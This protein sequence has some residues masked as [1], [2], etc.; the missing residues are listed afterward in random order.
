MRTIRSAYTDS[1]VAMFLLAYIHL[2]FGGEYTIRAFQSKR[3]SPRKPWTTRICLAV[4]GLLLILTWLPSNIIRAPQKCYGD[5]IWRPFRVIP[6]GLGITSAMIVIFMGMAAI[7]G[8][9]LIRT[10]NIDP[11]E[12]IAASRV[13]Y[14][15]IASIV[16][17]ILML[18]FF[19]QGVLGDFDKDLSSARLAEL[20]LVGAGII[21]SLIHIFLRTNALRTAL[22]PVQTAWTPKR[23]FR[24]FGNSDLEIVNISPPVNLLGP[25]DADYYTNEKDRTNTRNEY[26]IPD[27]K[28]P[29]EAENLYTIPRTPAGRRESKWPLPAEPLSTPKPAELGGASSPTRSPP[30]TARHKRTPTNYSLFPNAEDEGPKLPAA[31]YSPTSPPPV[32]KKDRPESPKRIVQPDRSISAILD[33]YSSSRDTFQPSDQEPLI[34]LQPT[35][36]T[37]LEKS[38]QEV[39]SLFLQPPAPNFAINNHRRGSSASSTATL[40]IGLRLSMAPSAAIG[41]PSSVPSWTPPPPPASGPSRLKALMTP[42]AEESESSSTVTTPAASSASQDVM[43]ENPSKLL[44]QRQM[45]RM[46]RQPGSSQAASQD[47]PKPNNGTDYFPKVAPLKPIKT[48]KELPPT[49]QRGISGLQMNPPTPTTRTAFVGAA[50]STSPSSRLRSP[51]PGFF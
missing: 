43:L 24:F 23:K 34:L 12:R 14:Y 17:Q 10:V 1:D 45:N 16:L 2:V 5:I 3:F 29:F 38:K 19:I 51:G 42:P 13:F 41:A 25:R 39:D 8:M 20:D 30:P 27:E 26:R 48:E 46:I 32:E 33:D 37:P 50:V 28:T 15:L 6:I 49:P 21:I 47:P 36:Y 35:T 44:Q 11:N 7:I 31:V 18:P 40:Q 4:F 9:R 22:K